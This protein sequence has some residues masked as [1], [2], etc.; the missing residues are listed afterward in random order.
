MLILDEKM[1]GHRATVFEENSVVFMRH[2]K[3]L[4]F[5]SDKLPKGYRA[6]WE[7]RGKL[8]V[9]KLADKINIDTKSDEYVNIIMNDGA[10]PEDDEFIEVH[11]FGPMSIRTVKRVLA[12]SP[13]KNSSR[14]ILKAL[15]ES[16]K[17]M[18]I[19]VTTN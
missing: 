1:I 16:L 17:K 11:I 9:A 18:N 14:I 3:I 10:V 5:E 2:H 15:K 8:G 13:R 19:E 4:V 12:K 6:T 7:S